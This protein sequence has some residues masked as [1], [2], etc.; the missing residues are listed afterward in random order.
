MSSDHRIWTLQV[1][2]AA[3]RS[4]LGGPDA[5]PSPS[6]LPRSGSARTGLC[7][8]SRPA[9]DVSSSA[10]LRW[11]CESDGRV[12]ARVGAQTGSA[13]TDVTPPGPCCKGS[14]DW[15]VRGK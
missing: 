3:A 2:R 7:L 14:F 15:V 4:S 10:T 12:L 13:G 1:C 9:L 11:R 6:L 8:S 5:G